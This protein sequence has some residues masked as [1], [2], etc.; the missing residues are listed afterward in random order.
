MRLRSDEHATPTARSRVD[1]AV[2]KRWF[3]VLSTEAS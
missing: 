2:M 1:A 3:P